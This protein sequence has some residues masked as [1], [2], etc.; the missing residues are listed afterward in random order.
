MKKKVISIILV[1]LML[2]ANLVSYAHAE[3]G[4]A[5][6]LTS[7]EPFHSEDILSCTKDRCNSC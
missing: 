7:H 5:A 4:D 6:S 3:T 2:G 1:I